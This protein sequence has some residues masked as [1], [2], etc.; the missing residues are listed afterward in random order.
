M[1]TGQS[2]HPLEKLQIQWNRYIFNKYTKISFHST[3]SKTEV[4]KILEITQGSQTF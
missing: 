3:N 4:L 1:G 2:L